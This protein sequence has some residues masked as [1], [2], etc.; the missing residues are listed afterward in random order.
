L[1]QGTGT[2]KLLYARHKKDEKDTRD[3][4]GDSKQTSSLSDSVSDDSMDIE[5]C[6]T[7]QSTKNDRNTDENNRLGLGLGLRL[8]L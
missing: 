2:A 6:K 7:Y 8:G 3:I 1:C 4:N 5:S